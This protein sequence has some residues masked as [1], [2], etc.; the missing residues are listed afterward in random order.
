MC[1]GDAFADI[2]RIAFPFDLYFIL[3]Q[4]MTA[5][6][7]LEAMDDD[8]VLHVA[9]IADEDMLAFVSSN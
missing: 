2:D 8:T 6:E 1:Q 5:L 4:F 3:D 9:V 7:R